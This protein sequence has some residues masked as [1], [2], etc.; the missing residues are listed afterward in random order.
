METE[1]IEWNMTPEE[2]DQWCKTHPINK[3]VTYSDK[4]EKPTEE[5]SE[6]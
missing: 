4:E 5:D 1:K 6:L 2:R 3:M